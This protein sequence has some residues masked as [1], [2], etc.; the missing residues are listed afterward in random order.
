MILL[1][2]SCV[3]RMLSGCLSNTYFWQCMAG[4]EFNSHDYYVCLKNLLGK[5]YRVNVTLLA[6]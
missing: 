2:L 1:I 4:K 3:K 6:K 5:A